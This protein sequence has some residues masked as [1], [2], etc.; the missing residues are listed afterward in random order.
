MAEQLKGKIFKCENCGSLL[1]F[2]P[3]S[4]KLKCAHCASL[5]DIENI[6]PAKELVYTSNSEISYVGWGETKSF[7]CRSCGAEYVLNEYETASNCPFCNASNVAYIDHIPGLKPNA[8]LPFKVTEKA[9]HDSYLNWLK[10]R[11]MA[12]FGFKKIAKKLSAKGVYIPLFTFDTSTYS[13]YH[14]K[15][16]RTH[17]KTVRVGNKMVTKTY[18][19]WYTDSGSINEDFNDIQIESSARIEQSDLRALEGFDTTNAYEYK[20]DFLAGFSAERYAEGLDES[21]AQAKDIASSCIRESILSR[22]S[23]DVLGYCNVNTTFADNTYKYVL[24]PVW[25]MEYNYKKK[26]YKC[27]VNARTG[28]CVGKAPV[29]ITKSSII[30]LLIAGA[31]VLIWYLLTH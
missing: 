28:K 22:Y 19:V 27:Y 15:Y 5:F 16:G 6:K 14:I 8:I 12:P 20:S 23:Y 18:T 4:G 10:K 17:T 7:K 11:H 3:A 31:A 1:S 21:F 9:A 2:D 30:G 24:V 13:T 26:T 25:A 29:S